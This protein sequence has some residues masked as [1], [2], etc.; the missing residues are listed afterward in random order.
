MF[1]RNKGPRPGT[2]PPAPPVP[3][4]APPAEPAVSRTIAE[5]TRSKAAMIGSTVKVKG[6][7]TSG[8]NLVIEG[9]VEGSITCNSHEVTVGAS[10]NVKADV[11]AKTIRIEGTVEGDI[12]GH[13]KVIITKSGKVRGNIVAPAMS[14]EDGA[15]F[16]GSIDMDPTP[17]QGSVLSMASSTGPRPA[18]AEQGAEASFRTGR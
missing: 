8:E 4:A 11:T 14:L 6:E 18:V 17:Q 15:K 5:P 1:E 16:K 12:T 3:P 9:Q 2:E 10:G 7:I 13:E